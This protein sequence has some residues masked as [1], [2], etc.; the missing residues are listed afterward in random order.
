M[1]FRTRF[2]VAALAAST[3]LLLSGCAA[4]GDLSS[5]SGEEVP[6]NDPTASLEG[7]TLTY[8]GGAVADAGLKQV[9][10]AFAEATG[11]TWKQV[12]YPAP[13]E[14]SL[15]T[16]VAAGDMPDL[17]AWQP[18][19]S[20]L[21]ALQAERN[22]LPL[23]DAPWLDRLDP[24][25]RDVSGILDDTRYAA[26]VSSP[27][28]MG[29]YYNKPAFE[30]AGITS[31][32]KNWDELIATAEKIKASGG[33]AFYEAG[34]A[35]WPT[36]WWVQVQLA[37]AAE[38]GLWEDINTNKEQFTGPTITDAITNY[39]DLFAQGLFNSDY[40]TGTF[41]NQAAALLS[42][43]AAM[44]VQVNA[45]LLQMQQTSTTEDIDANIG[46]F[47]ISKD[48][49]LATSIPDNKNGVVAFRTGDA[50]REAAAK[51]FL[52]FWLTTDYPDYLAAVKGVSIQTDVP[53]PDGVPEVASTIAASLG[54]SVG[55]MQSLAIANPDLYINL[56]NMLQGTVTPEDVAS[57][58][59][60]QFEQ[61]AKAQGAE[62][63]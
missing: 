49:S 47:P 43:D 19:A 61:F 24:S 2:V 59:Q 6:W 36:Q 57:T 35:Q 31:E 63:F 33:T 14:Q 12:A 44:S 28:V 17:A 32:P 3:A 50:E 39:N 20:S 1:T 16:K 40:K 30:S 21:S 58:T 42:G 18:T 7:V 26:L 8:G 34:G 45:L 15:L 60:K 55:S 9:Q 23:D 56:A 54:S 4:G 52:N 13:Y 51:Q 29:V 38:N 22:L 27:S 46:W 48:G 11:V 10:D 62:G 25:V 41:E 5:S 53:T 37:E